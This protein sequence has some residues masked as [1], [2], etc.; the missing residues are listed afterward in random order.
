MFLERSFR[1]IAGFAIRVTIVSQDKLHT[2]A[3]I[4]AQE[5]ARFEFPAIVDNFEGIAA[6]KSKS[7]E[8][9]VYILSDD[10]YNPLQR[11]L[12]LMFAFIAPQI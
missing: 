5:I 4:T 8:T 2:G 7:G 6:R 10:N 12:L 11:T 9:L 1:F 3:E